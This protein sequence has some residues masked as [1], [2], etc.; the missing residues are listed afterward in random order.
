M[1]GRCLGWLSFGSPWATG[2]ILSYAI[3]ITQFYIPM[4]DSGWEDVFTNT[5]GSVVGFFLFELLGAPVIR[6]LS[7]CE[8]ALRSWLTLSAHCGSAS[9]LFSF[10][11]CDFC[12]AANA[13]DD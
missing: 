5:T 10:M 13:N 7:Q 6:F 1:N 3:E 4:R 2:A 9:S 12:R 8:A 11:V